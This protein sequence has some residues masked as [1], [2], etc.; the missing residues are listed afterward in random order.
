M[1]GVI[2]PERTLDHVRRALRGHARGRAGVVVDDIDNILQAHRAGVR[3]SAAFCTP[4]EV[5]AGET[6]SHAGLPVSTVSDEVARH[7]FG[8]ERASRVFA[9]AHPARPRPLRSLG[10]DERDLVILDG[11]RLLGNIGAII[12]TTA[13]LGGS[14]LVL[15]NSGLTSIYDR[16]LIRASRGLVF[17]L[18]TVL[19]TPRELLRFGDDQQLPLVVS[20]TGASTDVTHLARLAGRVGLVFG[21][22]R[23]GCSPPLERTAT[24]RV[25]IGMTNR[26]E[27]LN[28]SVAAGIVLNTRSAHNLRLC[29]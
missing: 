25:S 29:A 12:R 4:S 11:V 28:V 26:V 9:L 1:V 16:R 14:G 19:S 10:E 13:A 22:E 15:L 7:L 5:T 3:I 24:A 21:G 17:H 27:S 6:L 23:D 18:P 2:A 20:G 8:T